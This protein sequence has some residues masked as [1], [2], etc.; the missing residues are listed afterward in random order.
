MST[1]VDSDSSD[2]LDTALASCMGILI[3]LFMIPHVVYSIYDYNLTSITIAILEE[4]TNITSI[5]YPKTVDDDLSHP[6]IDTCACHRSDIKIFNL[7]F[8][9]SGTQS[10]QHLLRQMGCK[11]IHWII[12]KPL[13]AINKTKLV[14]NNHWGDKP[15]PKFSVAQ[16][17]QW[18][19]NDGEPA[20]YYF[21]DDINGITQMDYC[22]KGYCYWPQLID[23]KLMEQQYPNALFILMYRNITKHITSI[24]NWYDMRERFIN[25]EI[26]CLP[27]G[28]GTTDQELKIWINAHYKNVTEYFNANESRKGKLLMYHIEN[29]KVEKL[30]EF[31]GCDQN[32]TLSHKH[33][34][35]HMHIKLKQNRS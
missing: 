9:K 26:P 12:S 22:R 25:A 33:N 18:A 4:E 5:D 7:G 16:L 31:L 11:S 15:K 30:E 34:T 24:N 8:P 17:M 28:K 13:T 1:T 6:S 29:D 21:A 32:Y 27:A 20:L 2:P 35:A 23:F 14:A 19:K 3:L 10:L